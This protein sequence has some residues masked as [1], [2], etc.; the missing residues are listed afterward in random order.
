MVGGWRRSSTRNFFVQKELVV[1][2][3]FPRRRDT[4]RILPLVLYSCIHKIRLCIISTDMI[5]YSSGITRL[6]P[7]VTACKNSTKTSGGFCLIRVRVRLEEHI[8]VQ[9][10]EAMSMTDLGFIKSTCYSVQTALK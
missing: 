9:R 1:L 2:V 10:V 8:L 3:A 5:G 4:A 7:Y 6:I